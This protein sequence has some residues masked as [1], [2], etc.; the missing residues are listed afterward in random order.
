MVSGSGRI[1]LYLAVA[2]VVLTVVGV[3]FV[4]RML[5]SSG[6]SSYRGLAES[7]QLVDE[8][9]ETQKLV[10]TRFPLRSYRSSSE[11]PVEERQPSV[12]AEPSDSPTAGGPD[13]TPEQVGLPT[14]AVP[15]LE[16]NRP[17]TSDRVTT[18]AWLTVDSPLHASPRTTSSRLGTADK[19]TQ[20]RWVAEAEPGW[21]EL[22]LADERSVYVRSSSL[23]FVEPAESNPRSLA[24]GIEIDAAALA[25]TVDGFLTA[26]ASGDLLRAETHLES[27]APELHRE[28]LSGLAAFTDSSQRA[29]LDRIEPSHDGDPSLRLVLLDSNQMDAQPVRTLWR[30]DG[31]RGRWLLSRWD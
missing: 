13:G 18:R 28:T 11:Q 30:W 4:P 27:G 24:T 31:G 6:S 1:Y 29:R 7:G 26:L 16:A 19:G 3:V 23:T 5:D 20:V 17:R 8:K 14:R 25:P 15:G 2:L 10:S 22:L 21:E 12:E 9:P